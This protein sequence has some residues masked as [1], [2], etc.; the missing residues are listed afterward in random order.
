MASTDFTDNTTVV[1]ASWLD[2]IDAVVYEQTG[3]GKTTIAS[4]ATPDIFAVTTGHLIDYTGTATCTG[5][6]AAVSAGSHRTLYCAGAAVF[7]AGANLLIDGITSGSNLT[8]VAG[9]I[10]E[11][12]ANTTTQFKITKRTLREIPQLSKSTAYTTVIGDANTHILH[13]TADNNARTFTIDA[14]ATVAYPIGTTLTFV[15]QINTLTIA[16]TTDTL[17]LAGAGTTGSRTLA[18]NGIATALKIAST[19]WIIS[20]VGLT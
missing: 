4:A 14:N 3:V 11:V 5:F 6:V 8:C 1:P 20:G 15:N 7:T 2:D 16:I 10:L 17:T 12:V 19:S 9:D 18:A 13:P